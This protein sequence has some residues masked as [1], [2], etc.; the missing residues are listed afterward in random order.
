MMDGETETTM[1][2]LLSPTSKC[3]ATPKILD[4]RVP[5]RLSSQATGLKGEE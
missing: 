4:A 3:C 1:A 2:A 5:M